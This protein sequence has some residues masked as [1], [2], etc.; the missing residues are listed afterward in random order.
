MLGE[1][2]SLLRWGGIAVICFGVVVVGR[3]APKT[4]TQPAAETVPSA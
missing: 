2:V 1:H 3:T 4:T